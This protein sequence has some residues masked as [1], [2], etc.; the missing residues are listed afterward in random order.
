[1]TEP[2]P[3]A[4]EEIPALLRGVR[5]FVLDY[6]QFFSMQ[7]I[8]AAEL[9]RSSDLD[10]VREEIAGGEPQQGM[11]SPAGGYLIPNAPRRLPGCG[12]LIQRS[13][14]RSTY[15]TWHGSLMSLR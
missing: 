1:M 5:R 12:T 2:I 3:I 13:A 14:N 6:P 11:V 10:S 4:Y 8:Y 15:S 7:Q 9:M